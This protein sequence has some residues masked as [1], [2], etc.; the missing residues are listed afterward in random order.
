MKAL[1]FV[2]SVSFF[3]FVVRYGVDRGVEK[4]RAQI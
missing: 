4:P 1:H 2:C 3:V